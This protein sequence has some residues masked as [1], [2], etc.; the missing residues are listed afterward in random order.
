M[1]FS[2]DDAVDPTRQFFRW[3]RDIQGIRALAV[4]LFLAYHAE[5]CPVIIGKMVIYR[6]ESHISSAY[7]LALTNVLQREIDFSL[8]N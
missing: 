2:T 7:A 3:R 6:D 5:I 1:F 4:L 8:K